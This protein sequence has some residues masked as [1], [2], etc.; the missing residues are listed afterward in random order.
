[1]ALSSTSKWSSIPAD[2]LLQIINPHTLADSEPRFYWGKPI[3]APYHTPREFD[4]LKSHFLSQLRLVCT[5]WYSILT[6]ALYQRTLVRVHPTNTQ[7]QE[8]FKRHPDLIRHLIVHCVPYYSWRHTSFQPDL[9]QA[10]LS[11]C[12]SVHTLELIY[13]GGLYQGLSRSKAH[14][15]FQ[16]FRSPIIHLRIVR[17]SSE[18]YDDVSST[19]LGLGRLCNGLTTLEIWG[20]GYRAPM[21]RN[22]GIGRQ[23]RS[24]RWGLPQ[25]LPN[26]SRL[27]LSC[28]GFFPSF[29][30]DIISRIY[31]QIRNTDG[32]KTVT[33][34]L[35]EL[36]LDG[37]IGLLHN[38]WVARVLQ[39]NNIAATL[40]VFELSLPWDEK[41]DINRQP[42]Y[43]EL[44][45]EIIGKCRSLVS[46]RYYAHFTTKIFSRLSN[47]TSELGIRI[48]TP[49]PPRILPNTSFWFPDT[50]ITG[51]QPIIDF[52]QSTELR[53][54][55]D[56]LV[57]G[58]RLLGEAEWCR[59]KE[60]CSREGVAVEMLP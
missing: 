35:R 7:Y 5:H 49:P 2:I 6:P 51:V 27:A 12:R 25:Y 38:D 17:Y 47:T 55:V 59:L 4:H 19:L 44:P 36:I 16:G 10:C 46:F 15:L 45:M 57:I 23:P 14:A 9:L 29:F 31:R 20:G 39:I 21:P 3:R 34:P 40:T 13:M 22:H 30:E 37:Q 24:Q 42:H 26:I 32:S 18:H 11:E 58:C 56:S 48:A 41:N 8:A 60:A 43:E 52:V 1:M 54:G 28:Q 33:T 53:K 50:I